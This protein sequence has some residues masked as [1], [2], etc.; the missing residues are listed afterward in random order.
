MSGL[1]YIDEYK[2]LRAEIRLYLDRRSK[3]LQ[4]T[5]V[6]VAGTI[7]AGAG[8]NQ[9]L[10]F[11]ISA[12]LVGTLW[13]NDVRQGKA[14]QRI[15]AYLARY[16]EPNVEGLN[17]ETL[18]RQHQIQTAVVERA[19]ASSIYPLLMATETVYG[20]ILARWDW[21]VEAAAGV[22]MAVL[23]VV[24]MS[25]SFRRTR[26]GRIVEDTA[27]AAVDEKQETPSE[28]SATSAD[29]TSDDKRLAPARPAAAPEN[30]PRP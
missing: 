5:I 22:A 10:L 21:R 2:E 15:A 17:W 18:G 26:R 16:V 23:I 1:G 9:P 27:W 13:F 8:L 20:L 11:L 6:L 12:V 25:W 28:M 29:G 7:G 19:F 24:L 4:L 14:V 30:L 3:M